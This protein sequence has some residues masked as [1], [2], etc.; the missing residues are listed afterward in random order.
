MVDVQDCIH[1][2][3][4]EFVVLLLLKTLSSPRFSCREGGDAIGRPPLP[5]CPH[6]CPPLAPSALT[7]YMLHLA[8]ALPLCQGS[9]LSVKGQ[10]GNTL[11]FASVWPLLQL[12]NAA[13]EA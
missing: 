10:R 12:F 2:T 6:S 7:S 4:L 3:T 1:P 11:W 5:D 9:A 8:L 13:I